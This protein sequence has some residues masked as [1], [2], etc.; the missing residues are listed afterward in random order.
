M[1]VMPDDDDYISSNTYNVSGVSRAH[2]QEEQ[3]CVYIY[4]Y[5]LFFLEDCLLHWPG[6]SPDNG[7]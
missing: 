6:V 5:L 7:L 1:V 2:H 3:P 4:W